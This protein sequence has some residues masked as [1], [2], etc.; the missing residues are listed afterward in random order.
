MQD[1][2]KPVYTPRTLLI[3]GAFFIVFGIAIGI[4]NLITHNNMDWYVYIGMGLVF[5][6][7]AVV[8]ARKT[9]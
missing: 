8:T 7:F 1:R 6:L 9:W 2:K 4:Y 5:W 3:I